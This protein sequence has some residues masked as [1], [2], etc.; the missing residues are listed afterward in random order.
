M[1]SRGSGP[2]GRAPRSEPRMASKLSLCRSTAASTGRSKNDAYLTR[3]DHGPPGLALEP[4]EAVRADLHAGQR[5][6]LVDGQRDLADV[7]DC[8]V[9]RPEL[10][11]DAHEQPADRRASHWTVTSRSSPAQP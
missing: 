8:Q 2:P 10:A 3:V 11:D 1:D 9:N 4:D 5:A 7:A 6:V